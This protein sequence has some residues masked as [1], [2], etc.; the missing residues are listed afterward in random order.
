MLARSC[1]GIWGKGFMLSCS[2][3]WW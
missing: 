3:H 1:I 2:W